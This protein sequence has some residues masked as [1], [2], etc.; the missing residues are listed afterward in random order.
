MINQR[1]CCRFGL[2][3]QFAV[4]TLT[5]DLVEL[6]RLRRLGLIAM[7]LHERAVRRF[8]ERIQQQQ[9]PGR[10]GRAIR[11]AGSQRLG[12]QVRER[13][14]EQLAQTLTFDQQPIL[15]RWIVD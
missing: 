12:H 5:K 7:N 10:L 8:A 9:F 6:E 1:H 4:N 13:M 14:L 3:A 11:I 2:H 15:K